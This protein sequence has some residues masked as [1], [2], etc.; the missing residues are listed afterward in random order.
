ML[1]LD[2]PDLSEE[3]LEAAWQEAFVLSVSAL[4]RECL[5]TAGLSVRE[6]GAIVAHKTLINY[7]AAYFFKDGGLC[8]RLASDV[9]KSKLF[10]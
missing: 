3:I 5:A 7:I 6:N 2:L 9:V 1:V 10:I 4:D 8:G